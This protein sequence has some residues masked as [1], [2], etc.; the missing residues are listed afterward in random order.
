MIAITGATGQ[1]GQRVIQHI[2]T[3]NPNASIVG[4]VRTPSNAEH[5]NIPTRQGN[6]HDKASLINAFQGVTTLVLISS[7][8]FN[9]RLTQHINAIEAA[10]VAQVQHIIYTSILHADRWPIAFANDHLETEKALKASGINYTILRNTWYIENHTDTLAHTLALGVLVGS[11]GQ[12]KIS[13]ATRDN[14]AE[15]AAKVALNANAHQNQIYELAGDTAYTL[16]DIASHVANISQRP[17]A[18]QNVDE[19]TH[20]NHLGGQGLPPPIANLLAHLEA[21]GVST[22]ILLNQDQHLSKLLGH[23]TTNYQALVEQTLST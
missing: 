3:I 9:Q 12:A 23:P 18:Y 1:L 10:K 14:L 11:A 6:Y 19:Q 16:A 21:Q 2:Q 7:S 20:A 8:D 5:L 17:Y 13:G 22:G 4:L 15:A